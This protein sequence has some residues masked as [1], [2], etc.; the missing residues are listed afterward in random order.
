MQEQDYG[1]SCYEGIGKQTLQV[2]GGKKLPFKINRLFLEVVLEYC[3]FLW[4]LL[5]AFSE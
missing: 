4:R 3:I 1:Y 5:N 2:F